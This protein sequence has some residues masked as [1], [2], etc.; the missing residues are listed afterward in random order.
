MQT[1]FSQLEIRLS[2]ALWQCGQ[3]RPL[4]HRHDSNNSRALASSPYAGARSVKTAPPAFICE[5]FMSANLPN[6]LGHPLS[7]A[8]VK[9]TSPAQAR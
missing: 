8:F 4:G 6:P 9:Y 5:V 2:P 1:R 3:T 7:N